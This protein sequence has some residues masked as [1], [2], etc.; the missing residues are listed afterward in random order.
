MK[1][2]PALVDWIFAGLAALFGGWLVL[3]AT[4]IY[5]A[6]VSSDSAFYLSTAEN[7]A[8]GKGLFDLLGDPFVLWPPLYP[9]I[10]G[11]FHWAS[12]GEIT[13]FVWGRFLNALWM[14]ALIFS[15]AVLYWRCFPGRRLW[16]YLGTLASLTFT[17][18][19]TLATNIA[20]DVLFILLMVCFFLAAQMYLSRRDWRWLAVLTLISA[21]SAMLRWS[22]L[23]MI[24]TQAILVLIVHWKDWKK[25][26][27]NGLISCGLASLPFL[28]WVYGRNYLLYG[29]RLG[30]REM[31]FVS[32]GGNLQLSL[33]RI[34]EWFPALDQT[35]SIIAFLLLGAGLIVLI[36][37]NQRQDW[38][39][40]VR[41]LFT[42]PILPVILLT[43]IYIVSILFTSYTLDHLEASDDRYQVPLLFAL[44]IFVFASLD[45][46]VFPH[47][48][49]RG[50]QFGMAG[51]T[52][53][54]LAWLIYPSLNLTRFVADSHE[55][56]VTIYNT[57]NTRKMDRS[58]L[59]VMLRKEPLP[60]QIPIYSNEPEVVYFWLRRAAHMSP[61]DPKN[62]Y[63]EIQ[64]LE[65]LYATWPPEEQAYLIW[66]KPNIKNNYYSPD[67]LVQLA[68]ME[69]L[70]K[71]YDGE[72]YLIRPRR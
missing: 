20:T 34:A 18:F 38:Q 69:R 39:R 32:V 67:D 61:F 63:A 24:V 25:A 2:F 3:H 29:S 27:W 7:F 4:A 47:L 72:L 54:F 31:R 48:Q 41:R 16:F 14:S 10:L 36:L 37:I 13:P 71:H 12:A 56:G 26:V 58:P 28:L 57:Y 52:I 22:G 6:G 60:P 62:Y 33:Q 45:E 40:W 23:A 70:Y 15:S 53:L 65:T 35:L 59:V 5:G 49:S 9:F 66:F 11:V 43:T 50:L 44:L 21:A 30:N 17:G 68:E 1:T 55:R 46:L 51:F 8:A 42:N 64:N 19:Y